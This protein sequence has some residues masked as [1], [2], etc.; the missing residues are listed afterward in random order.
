MSEV[1]SLT[2]TEIMQRI[3]GYDSKALEQ[4]YDRYTPLLYTLIRR[5]IP[6][7][8]TAE[9][10]LSEVFAIIWRQIDQ[11]D[12]SKIN[13]YTWIVTLARNKAIDVKNRTMGKITEEYTEEYEKENILPKLSLEIESVELEAVLGMKEK[14][15]GAIKSLTDAQRYVIELSYYEGLDESGIAEKL[16]IPSSTVKSKLLVA[17]GNLMKK[18]SKTN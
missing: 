9:E 4:L 10:V 7:K 14:I 3:A 15:E 17:I 18:I 2:D 8:E 11:F 16:K 12:F 5:I 13:I 6:D 1:N